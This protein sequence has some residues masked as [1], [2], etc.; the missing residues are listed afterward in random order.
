MHESGVLAPLQPIS[1]AATLLQMKKTDDQIDSVVEVCKNLTSAQ[2]SSVLLVVLFP[3]DNFC[4]LKTREILF[5]LFNVPSKFSLK[6]YEL[7]CEIV[8]KI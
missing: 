7:S 3:D 5:Q 4:S 8:L 1:E 6:N 2:V